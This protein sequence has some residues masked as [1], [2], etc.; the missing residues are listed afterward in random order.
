MKRSS[1]NKS[2]DKK[3]QSTVVSTECK[4]CGDSAV[5]S[6]FGVVSCNSCKVFFKRNAQQR[7]KL[8]KC[9]WNGDCEINI[10]TRH[11]CA[12]CRLCKCFMNGMQAEMIRGSYSKRY[13]IRKKTNDMVN[14]TQTT[15]STVVARLNQLEQFPTLNLLQ[16]DQSTLTVDQW[17]L[18]SN[19]SHCYNEHSG[20]SI[21]E[22]FM[23][24]QNKLPLKLRF[25]SAPVIE[26]F[27]MELDQ[28]QLLYKNNRDF[29]DLSEDDRSILLHYSFK[30]TATISANFIYHQIGLCN[31]PAFYDTVAL[32]S[33]PDVAIATKRI[34]SLLNFDIIT[35]K[36]FLAILSFSTI[37]YIT[38][39]STSS[40]N[41]TNMKQILN[42]QDRYIELTWKY[43]LYKNTYGEVI[44]Y[45]SDLVRYF[46]A[47]HD[48]LI[49][50]RTVQWLAD[51]IDSLVKQ[52]KRTLISDK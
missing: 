19:L 12:S 18:L 6:F 32:V 14:P 45:F 11:V 1:S 47:I 39:T 2:I 42:I 5:H 40:K 7:Q 33:N 10:N 48:A 38:D 43:L 51:E 17:N 13:I 22:N 29:V 21:G 3:R 37:S 35:M 30:Y 36:L 52:T 24:Q 25:K 4:I 46:F 8:L 41:Y 26:F 31:Y 16:S 20:L 9:Y 49:K 44:K 27:R 34:Q 50:A 23:Y 15:T 28:T